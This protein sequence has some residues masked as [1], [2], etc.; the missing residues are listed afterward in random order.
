MIEMNEKGQALAPQ[1]RPI[2]PAA[3]TDSQT[4]TIYWLGNGGA[5]MNSH[6]TIIMID[7]LLEG[8]DMPLLRET[9]ILPQNVQ[10]CD[11]VLISHC[12]NDHFSKMTCV[13]LKKRTHEYHAPHYVVELM[14]DIGINGVGHNIYDEFHIQDVLVKVTPADH[15]WQNDVEKHRKVREWKFDEYCGYWFETPEGKIWYPGDSRLLEEQLH[16]DNPDVILL[17]FADNSW[18]ITLEGAVK[19]ANAY[20]DA[21][22]I[23]IHYGCVDAPEMNPFNGNPNELMKRIQ[24]PQRLKVLAPGEPF[25]VK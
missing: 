5:M 20:P 25:T 24:N 15:A 9:P 4:T 18:H 19:L 7:P 16:M 17:D 6:G 21:I 10:K 2:T 13:D 22:L 8:F 14:K 11:A 12:D 23:P 1:T 3:F